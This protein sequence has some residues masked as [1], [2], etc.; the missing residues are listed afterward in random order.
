[1]KKLDAKSMLANKI[2][3]LPIVVSIWNIATG[4]L[5]KRFAIEEGKTL[6][7]PIVEMYYKNEKLKIQV[8]NELLVFYHFSVDISTNL[9]HLFL[10]GP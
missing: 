5:A 2:D 7:Y 8:F 1:M 3:L 6:E 10:E 9:Q 4:E